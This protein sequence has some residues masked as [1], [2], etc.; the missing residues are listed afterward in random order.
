[1]ERGLLSSSVSLSGPNGGV[2][3][4]QSGSASAGTQSFVFLLQA[5]TT[6]ETPTWRKT[7]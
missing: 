6:T 2:C 7:V 3:D 5:L 4:V 1:M